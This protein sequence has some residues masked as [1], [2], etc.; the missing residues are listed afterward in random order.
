ML[1]G[2][3]LNNLAFTNWMHVLTLKNEKDDSVKARIL[4][5]ER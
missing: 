1:E 5:E 2:M 3:L 4:K